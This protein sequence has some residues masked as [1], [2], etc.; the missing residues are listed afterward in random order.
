MLL[1]YT[2]KA[3]WEKRNVRLQGSWGYWYLVRRLSTVHRSV[4]LLGVFSGYDY[5]FATSMVGTSV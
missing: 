3:V 4:Y 1:G 2:K 5:Y